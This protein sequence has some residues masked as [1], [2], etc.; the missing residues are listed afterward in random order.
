MKIE[1]KNSLGAIVLS[2]GHS[3]GRNTC[4]IAEVSGLGLAPLSVTATSFSGMDGAKTE[5]KKLSQ[6][7]I[8]I[9]IDIPRRSY[10]YD[11][12]YGNLLRV[13]SANGELFVYSKRKKRRIEAF[14]SNISEG[15]SQGDFKRIVITF[16]CDSPYFTDFEKINVP[17]LTKSKYLETTFTLP[18]VFSERISR[19]SVINSGDITAEPI[20]TFKNGVDGTYDAGG[21]LVLNNETTGQFVT[22]NYYPA[23]GETVTIDIS[24]RTITSD[25]G[26]N[27][28]NFISDETDLSEFWL[29]LGENVVSAESNVTNNRV[30]VECSFYNR[31]IEGVADG[32]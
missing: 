12:F 17:L 29:A 5:S 18:C 9:A 27:L 10:D 19:A 6:R 14:V 8:N 3:Y 4:Y 25:S 20:I 26:A 24:N 13:L 7:K 16:T 32:Y 1:F 23:P 15:K 21:Y 31:Y 2:G 30:L 22:L 11:V 28:I